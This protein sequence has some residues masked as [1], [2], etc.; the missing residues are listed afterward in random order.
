MLSVFRDHGVIRKSSRDNLNKTA[1]NRSIY[2][3][4]DNGWLVVNRMKAWQGSVGISSLRGI[5]SGHYLCFR[6]R[7]NEDNCFLNWLLRSDVYTLEYARMS[8]GVRP[9]QI[10]IDNDELRGLRIALP[11][12]DEQH[13]IADFL[14]AEA[15]RIEVLAASVRRTIKL[16][17]ERF[18][19]ALEEAFH[20]QDGSARRLQLRRVVERW[21]DYRGSTPEKVSSGI[22]LVTAKNIARGEISLAAAPEFISEHEY[23]S[24]MVRGLPRPGD[25]LMTT[26]APL[27]EVATVTDANIALAQRIILIRVDSSKVA[28]EWVYWYLQSPQGQYELYSRATGST[29]L[30]IKAD[31][32]YG[33]PI[34]LFTREQTT[35]RLRI[36][37]GR[38][39][40]LAR[41]TELSKN[42]LGLLLE[43]RQ[44]L[45]T[46]AVTGQ[47]DVT[48]GQGFDWPG[49]A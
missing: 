24:W 3:L 41:L 22:P 26:E 37:Q 19:S 12:I 14:D 7:H 35:D 44:A 43:R 33:V 16:Q 6:P 31:R 5:V 48:T 39:S 25:V 23:G 36:L 47:F 38:V 13:R 18:Y 27:G 34:P 17:E 4:I 49:G 9:G 40:S 28:P 21:I 1:E 45:I 11:P 30:G 42:Q 10:E 2:Q 20:D 46:A 32:L 15:R 29:A 8:R